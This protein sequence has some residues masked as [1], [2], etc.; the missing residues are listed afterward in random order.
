MFVYVNAQPFY[1]YLPISEVPEGDAD[2]TDSRTLFM[3]DAGLSINLPI[4]PLV[5][6][7]RQVDLMISFDFSAQDAD[8][9]FPFQVSEKHK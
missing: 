8:N 5:K 1:S 4:P 7:Q 6:P 3:V 9:E 2:L